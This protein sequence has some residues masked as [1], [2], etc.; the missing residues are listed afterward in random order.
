[1]IILLYYIERCKRSAFVNRYFG[2]KIGDI[3]V[4]YREVFLYGAAISVH[5]V[6]FVRH[7]ITIYDIIVMISSLIYLYPWNIWV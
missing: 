6:F 1:M 5:K 4:F 3:F 7:V 2:H